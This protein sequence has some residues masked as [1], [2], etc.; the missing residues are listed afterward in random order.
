MVRYALII[1]L[2][3]SAC[4]QVGTITGGPTDDFA[5][6]VLS[7]SIQDQQV[8]VKAQQQILVFDEF[9]KLNDAQKQITLMPNDSRLQYTV[10][11]KVL[12]IDFLDSLKAQTT[13]TLMSNGGVQDITEGNDS[14]MT[15]TFSTGKVLDSMTLS[16]RFTELIPEKK[17]GKVL[18]G[19]YE[20]DSSKT[21]RYMGMF[22]DNNELKIKGLKDG[23]YYLKAFI[24]ADSDGACGPKESQ[25]QYFKQISLQQHQQDTLFF[26]LSKPIMK[27]TAQ[28]LIAKDS[29]SITDSVLQTGTLMVNWANFA[30][31]SVLCIYQNEQLI[32]NQ[33]ISDSLTKL[34]GLKPGLYSLHFFKDLNQNGQW[35]PINPELQLRAEPLFIYPEKIKV[36]A[37]WDIEVPLNKTLNNLLEP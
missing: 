32:Q 21:A 7:A 10:K 17:T 20:T 30:P 2:L 12:T 8:S 4:A 24:D 36:K 27:D 11:G 13:Y 25:D 3:L 19:L 16:A 9:I 29:S 5:P 6:K 1:S 35:D 26:Y 15:W 14:L 34:T 22:T 37:N 33:L 31:G 28:K 23:N 18:L